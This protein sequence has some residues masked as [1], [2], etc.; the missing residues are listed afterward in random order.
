M[1]VR[2]AVEVLNRAPAD[3]STDF[4]HVVEGSVEVRSGCLVV[5]G[6]TDFEPDAVRFAVPAGALRV[7]VGKS[8]LEVAGRLGIDSDEDPATME[9]IRAQVWPAATAPLLVLKRWPAART[10]PATAGRPAVV[11]GVVDTSR[12]ASGVAGIFDRS[13]L[14]VVAL[15]NVRSVLS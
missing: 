9:H 13:C 2:V 4:D 11:S 1:C 14:V 3:D 5:M 10:Y 15:K 6:C 8:N 12:S 7:R